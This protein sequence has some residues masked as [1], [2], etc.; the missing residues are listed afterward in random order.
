MKADGLV[1]GEHSL[2]LTDQSA[3]RSVSASLNE[4]ACHAWLH[5]LLSFIWSQPIG[6][7]DKEYHRRKP[8]LSPWVL[9]GLMRPADCEPVF[10][11]RWLVLP[12]QRGVVHDGDSDT[13]SIFKA[14]DTYMCAKSLQSYPTLCDPVDC[15]PPGSSVHGISQARILEW[16]AM[17][18]CRGSS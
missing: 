14:Q 5:P 9:S 16:V 7:G 4:S 13:K 12:K 6:L 11:R 15:S 18:S 1:W 10:L 2:F 17:S 3:S 8:V